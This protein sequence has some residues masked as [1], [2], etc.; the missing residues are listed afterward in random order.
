M[1][2]FFLLHCFLQLSLADNDFFFFTIEINFVLFWYWKLDQRQNL[3]CR[4]YS[5][6][7]I[8]WYSYYAEFQ[9]IPQLQFNNNIL[10][11]IILYTCLIFLRVALN[12]FTCEC[13]KPSI[14]QNTSTK[15]LYI[16]LFYM[17]APYFGSVTIADN[18]ALE[19]IKCVNEKAL[20]KLCI[21]F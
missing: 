15:Y 17:H 14:R 19:H 4:Q 13:E 18:A 1:H 5:Y 12:F 20:R 8:E 21:S 11:N 7:S 9:N 3:S 10:F 2:A 16:V 6:A